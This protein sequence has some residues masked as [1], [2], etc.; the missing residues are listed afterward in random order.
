MARSRYV[1]VGDY[2]DPIRFLILYEDRSVIAIDKPAGW[3]LVPFSWQ[4]TQ[5]NLQAAITS[6]IEAREFW[7]KSRNLR[8]LRA[9][10]RLDGDTSGILLMARSPGAVDSFS[11]LFESRRMRKRYLA[12]VKGKP[13]RPEWTCQLPLAPDPRHIGRMVVDEQE[14]KDAETRFHLLRSNLTHSLL[15][16]FPRT[17]RTHQIRVHLLTAGLPIVGDD[18]YGG[19]PTGSDEFPLGLRA[20]GLEYEDPFQRRTIRI[21]AGAEDFLRTFGFAPS[22][23]A[24]TTAP[25]PQPPAANA[26]TTPNKKPAPKLPP[27]H[28]PPPRRP[29]PKNP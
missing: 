8:F 11:A 14:G 27:S 19:A 21:R 24:E 18:L 5:R 7:A 15:E 29:T 13:A 26:S 16:V 10:H 28:R 20:V 2:R 1:E 12:V 6:A 9:V 3:L 17:G 22:L 25:P 23:A 4:S